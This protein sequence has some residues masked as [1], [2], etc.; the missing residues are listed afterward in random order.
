MLKQKNEFH[1][2]NLYV[3]VWISMELKTVAWQNMGIGN[4]FVERR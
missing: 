1:G 4:A 3:G 2:A